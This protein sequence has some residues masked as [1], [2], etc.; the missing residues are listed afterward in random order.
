LQQQRAPVNQ[1]AREM[2]SGQL[3][4][5]QVTMGLSF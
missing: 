2:V 5:S 4:R 3:H 1:V